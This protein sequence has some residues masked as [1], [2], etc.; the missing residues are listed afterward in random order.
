VPDLPLSLSAPD[1][2]T[3]LRKFAAD[4]GSWPLM[5]QSHALIASGSSVVCQHARQRG[6]R[7]VSNREFYLDTHRLGRSWLDLDVL[8]TWGL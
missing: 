5:S 7:K 4:H 6:R 3:N 1:M 8:E 2:S